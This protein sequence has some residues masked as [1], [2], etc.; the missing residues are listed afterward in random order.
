MLHNALTDV[1]LCKP[2]PSPS[3][4]TRAIQAGCSSGT[5]RQRCMVR[6][7]LTHT[8]VQ[9]GSEI[10]NSSVLYIPQSSLGDSPPPLLRLR[11]CQ[12][13]PEGVFQA[14]S[15]RS[16]SWRAFPR[17]MASPERSYA[18]GGPQHADGRLEHAARVVLVKVQILGH[19]TAKKKKKKKKMGKKKRK[20]KKHQEASRAHYMLSLQCPT[21]STEASATAWRR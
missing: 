4:H 12:G 3:S 6:W 7:R 21:Y 13:I 18:R 19:P 14:G 11:S 15:R 10:Q 5:Q 9:P 17:N 16:A 20:E 1:P 2:R 8:P